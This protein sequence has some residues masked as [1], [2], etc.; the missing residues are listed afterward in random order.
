MQNE[1]TSSAPESDE[2]EPKAELEVLVAP[3]ADAENGEASE[4]LTSSRVATAWVLAVSVA[5]VTAAGLQLASKQTEY[6]FF[7]LSL[8]VVVVFGATWSDVA[9]RRI[10]NVLTY[11]AI[12]LGLLLNGVAPWLVDRWSLGTAEV[13]LGASGTVQC[14]QG[15]GLCAAIGI[16][17]FMARGLGGGD[18]KLLAAVGAMM[19]FSGVVSVLF[20]TLLVAALIGLVNWVAGGSIMRKLQGLAH[21]VY[22]SIIMRA[23]MREVY[24]FRPSESPFALSLLIG[25]VSAQFVALHR[26]LFSVTW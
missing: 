20:N 17:S 15:F 3:N 6:G 8:C 12:A 23:D 13:F 10:P 7:L 24:R 9:T 19:G 1:I 2:S 25:L 21:S 4:E 26:E 22:F 14:L 11:P 5:A 16:V 18:V